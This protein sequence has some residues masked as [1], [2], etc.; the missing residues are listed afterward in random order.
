MVLASSIFVSKDII[1]P[2]TLS[3]YECGFEPIGSSHLPFCIKFFLLALFFLVFDVEIAFIVP[4]L[5][6]STLIFCFVIVLFLGLVFE[7]AFGGLSWVV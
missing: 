7:F 4:S 1:P 3:S 6:R 5:F 2:S